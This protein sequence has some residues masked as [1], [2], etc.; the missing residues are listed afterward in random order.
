MFLYL[1]FSNPL[2]PLT[3]PFPSDP[4][5]S[6]GANPNHA[7]DTFFPPEEV[8]DSFL[9]GFTSICYFPPLL[10]P[11]L[12]IT[13]R[14]PKLQGLRRGR[15]LVGGPYPPHPRPF[16]AAGNTLSKTIL[17]ISPTFCRA[18]FLDRWSPDG[19]NRAFFCTPNHGTY[20]LFLF[21]F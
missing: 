20:F 10:P 4:E 21:F 18:I 13:H 16:P 5:S 11:F 15:T 1:S 19:Q 12:T 8:F 17:S 6:Q 14:F 2:F 7:F 3:P 9:P